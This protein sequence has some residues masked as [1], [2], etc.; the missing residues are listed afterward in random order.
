MPRPKLL[1]LPHGYQTTIDEADAP[2]VEGLTVYRGKNGYAYYSVWSNGRSHPHTLHSL[3]VP[4]PAGMH[5]D[6]INGDKLDNRRANLR[7]VTPSV[8]QVNRK[9]TNRNN[10]SGVRGVDFAPSVS[11]AK[12]WRAQITS[13]GKNHYLG[14]FRTKEEAVA[15]R[16]AAE[17]K[18]YGEECPS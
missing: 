9:R 7:V 14:L 18:F 6:H 3:L 1:D 4:A 10:T 15:A 12:P 5:I 13:Q 2:R 8:N 17:V 11:A 16:K